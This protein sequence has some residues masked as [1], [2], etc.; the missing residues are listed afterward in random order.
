MRYSIAFVLALVLVTSPLSVGAQEEQVARSSWL[1]SELATLVSAQQQGSVISVD[2]LQMAW[3]PEHLEQ[4]LPGHTKP[5]QEPATI[6]EEGQPK[7]M[8][9]GGK[10][11][12]GVV[13]PLVVGTVIGVGIWA[14][15]FD[16]VGWE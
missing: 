4:R 14:A 8:S 16:W 10:I 11:A 12:V 7:G 13:V 6:T 3:I 9:R 5:S 1:E 2:R 15:N